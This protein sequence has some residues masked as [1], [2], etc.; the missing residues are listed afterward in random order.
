[1]KNLDALERQLKQTEDEQMFHVRRGTF[2]KTRGS[3][4]EQTQEARTIRERKRHDAL[5]DL[6][7]KRQVSVN[8]LEEEIKGLKK[9]LRGAGKEAADATTQLEEMHKD[10]AHDMASL[11]EQRSALQEEKDD[12]TAIKANL[13]HT[14]QR[15]KLGRKEGTLLL[16]K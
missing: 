7:Y 2:A 3:T 13:M 4:K 1:M 8:E 6:V 14:L 9:D 11:L 16:K 10:A 15:V 5:V 12:L